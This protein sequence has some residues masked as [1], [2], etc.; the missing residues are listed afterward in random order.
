MNELCSFDPKGEGYDM[1]H[2][3]AQDNLSLGISVVADCCNP[4]K[5]TREEWEN[6]AK[7]SMADCINIE[8]ICSDR[9]EHKNRVEKRYEK[10]PIYSPNWDKVLNRDYRPWHKEIMKFDTAYIRKE[11]IF[12]NF[13]SQLEVYQK[14][15]KCN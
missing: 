4:W 7:H 6:L 15:R 9:E 14:F 1:A 10:N 11:E 3:L 12:I 13:L 2:L 5:Q 8:I